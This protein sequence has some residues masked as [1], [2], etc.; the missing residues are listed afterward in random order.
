MQTPAALECAVPAA[1]DDLAQWALHC[2]CLH[3]R[4]TPQEVVR[5]DG[6]GRV[7]HACRHGTTRHGL[8]ER[9]LAVTQSQL[10]LLT[11]LSLLRP[12]GDTL[13]T[14]FPIIGP[15]QARALRERVEVVAATLAPALAMPMAL[16]EAQLVA[17][18][19][20]ASARAVVF[21]HALD[22]L[23]WDVLRYHGTI[24][25]HPL[26]LE[27]PYWNGTFWAIFPAHRAA[28]GVNRVATVDGG[29]LLCVW[30]A[31]SASA[32]AQLQRHTMRDDAVRG[33]LAGRPN[34]V[35]HF[36]DG[37][38]LVLTDADGRSRIPLVRCDA[39]DTLHVQALALARGGAAA[40]ARAGWV[41]AVASLCACS[42]EDAAV[43]A[44]HEMLWNLSARLKL[45]PRPQRAASTAAQVHGDL[46]VRVGA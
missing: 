32:V 39:S 21:G 42:E 20:A 19:W 30:D 44:G 14:T 25:E 15:T 17:A 6:N 23:F 22:G 40:L 26:S 33:L 3:A 27:R 10:M 7:L 24:D 35:L 28:L 16:L 13:R 37:G 2:F 1:P 9:G 45:A 11:L 43:I 29:E 8:V 18:G 41:P 46:F 36:A 4:R 5:I 12:S 38:A 31:D 34:I